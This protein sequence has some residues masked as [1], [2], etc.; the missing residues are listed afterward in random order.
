MCEDGLYF[1]QNMIP[2]KSIHPHV[3]LNVQVWKEGEM[4]VSYIP[5]LDLASCGE[6]LE[7]A[8]ANIREAFTLF[9]EESVKMGTTSRILEEAGFSVNRQKQWRAPEMVSYERLSVAM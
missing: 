7:N 1:N 4:F 9:I 3:E 5:Q 6:T 2:M 8:R